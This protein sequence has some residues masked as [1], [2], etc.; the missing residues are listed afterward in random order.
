MI[1][2]VDQPEKGEMG[3]IPSPPGHHL[4][5]CLYWRLLRDASCFLD[6]VYWWYQ[7]VEPTL[8]AL[9]AKLEE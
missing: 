8:L 6:G 7:E 1:S 4:K 9:L 5:F 2:R 3:F